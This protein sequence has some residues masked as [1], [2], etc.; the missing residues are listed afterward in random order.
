MLLPSGL[1]KSIVIACIIQLLIYNF[2]L[3]DLL[4]VYKNQMT[5][6]WEGFRDVDI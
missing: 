2:K 1:S 5:V 6:N 4:L 3:Q